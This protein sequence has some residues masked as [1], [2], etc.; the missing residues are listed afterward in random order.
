MGENFLVFFD[1]GG[2]NYA[3]ICKIRVNFDLNKNN[4][5]YEKT[6]I[7]FSKSIGCDVSGVCGLM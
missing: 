7:V 4:I 5:N 1:F 2:V 3:Y 6:S